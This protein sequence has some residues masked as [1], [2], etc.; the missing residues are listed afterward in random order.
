MSS[1]EA[2]A[3]VARAGAL[4]A[5]GA[6]AR[7]AEASAA[8]SFA[9]VV[10]RLEAAE[11]ESRGRAERLARAELC[12]IPT[13][14]RY[15]QLEC[16]GTNFWGLSLESSKTRGA[17]TNGPRIVGNEFDVTAVGIF[18][19]FWDTPKP[20]VG[21]HTGAEGKLARLAA[22]LDV[23]RRANAVLTHAKAQKERHLA[24]LARERDRHAAVSNCV[25]SQ[26]IQDTFNVSVPERIFGGS[27]SSRRKLGERIR[28]VQ[29]SWETSSM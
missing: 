3:R 10:E 27:L 4:A 24:V 14:S 2:E 8:A 20:V 6:R 15:L 18:E 9:A 26:P 17:N 16:S 7:R 28:T 21:F 12:G 1:A 19:D 29:E 11:A 23:E 5:A 13:D 22:S 25:E